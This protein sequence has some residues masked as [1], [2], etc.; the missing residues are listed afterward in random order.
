MRIGKALAASAVL[1]LLAG[2]GG[3]PPPAAAAP[4]TDTTSAGAAGAKASCGGADHTAQGHCGA[5]TPAASP[6]ASASAAPASTP[7]AAK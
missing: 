2:C 1:G 5:K 6:S 3:E 4:T 7:P